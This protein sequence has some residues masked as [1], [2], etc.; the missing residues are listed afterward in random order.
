MQK[1]L[2][3][4]NA[5]I[6]MVEDVPNHIKLLGNILKK[7]G[8]SFAIVTNAQETFE[9]LKNNTPDLILLDVILP[10]IDG[11]QIC[12]KLKE[13]PKTSDIPVIFLTAKLDLE[14]KNEQPRSRAPRYQNSRS[15]LSCST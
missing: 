2:K 3:K 11:F 10:G 8:Y 5:L 1:K 7:E 9:L 15:K 12:A 13:N 4:D 6:L 14:D